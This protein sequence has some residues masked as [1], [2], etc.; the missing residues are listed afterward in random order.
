MVDPESRAEKLT[1][2]ENVRR[3]IFRSK[4]VRSSESFDRLLRLY[5]HRY[6]LCDLIS[7]GFVDFPSLRIKED[8]PLYSNT[9]KEWS[10]S[11]G[12]LYTDLDTSLL[13]LDRD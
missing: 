2:G 8:A 12:A 4:V 13:R 5:I 3:A 9:G 10:S 1:G 11:D 6:S 7:T